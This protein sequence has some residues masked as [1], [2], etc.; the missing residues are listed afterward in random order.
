MSEELERELGE[1]FYG[2]VTMGERGQVVIPAQ[3]RKK[4]GIEPGDKLLVHAASSGHALVLIPAKRLMAM[5]RKLEE[6][7]G[8]SAPEL[9]EAPGK[10]ASSGDR[11]APQ[12][13]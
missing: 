7:T 5:M 1:E 4:L 12:E 3:A 8:E 9:E 13:G 6:L 11:L 2:A 10:G